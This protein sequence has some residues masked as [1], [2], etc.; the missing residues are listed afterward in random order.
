VSRCGLCN[1]PLRDAGS[2]ELGFGPGCWGRL[3]ATERASAIAARGSTGHADQPPGTTRGSK[4]LDPLRAVTAVP[5]TEAPATADGVDRPTQGS[6]APSRAGAGAIVPTSVVPR[7]S[8]SPLAVVASWTIVLL[9]V[10]VLLEYWRWVL[11]GV[12]FVTT[13]AVIGLLVERYQQGRATREDSA[14]R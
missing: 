4:G 8:T 14:E 13:V 12:T 3:S 7:R 2:I 11:M 10:F 5:G 6:D 1:R 9:A